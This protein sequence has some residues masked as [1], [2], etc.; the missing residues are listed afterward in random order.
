MG[1]RSK[2]FLPVRK[3]LVYMIVCDPQREENFQE[4]IRL[5]NDPDYYDV[6]FDEKS[7]G[8][9]AIHK[10]HQFDKT[11]GPFGYKRGLYE[12]I[13]LT[14]L[15]KHGHRIILNKEDSGLYL[16]KT[17]DG[18][19][20]GKTAEIKTIEG[21]GKWAIR[22]K[23]EVA[24]KQNAS[25][26]ILFFPTPETFSAKRIQSGWNDYLKANPGEE[27]GFQVFAIYGDTII[28][29]EKPPR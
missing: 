5:R 19:L 15:R 6:T 16:I 25:C 20:D 13:V 21:D 1:W 12:R 23:I 27:G 4:F 22:T 26:I 11:V 17:C 3:G 2:Q 29:I 7:G 24:R 9:S 14:A 8:V 18:F 10:E 28:E